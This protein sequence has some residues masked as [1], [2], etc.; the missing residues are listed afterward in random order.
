MIAPYALSSGDYPVEDVF[1][2]LCDGELVCM[3][4]LGKL[5]HFRCRRCGV[6]ASVNADDLPQEPADDDV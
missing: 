6:D 3:G 1:C 5:V 2:P 4:R